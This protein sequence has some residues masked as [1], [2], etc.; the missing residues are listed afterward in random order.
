MELLTALAV[1]VTLAV[2]DRGNAN[3]SLAAEG[4]FVA[5]VWS[6][7]A[8]GGATDIYSATSRDGGQTFSGPVRVNAKPGDARVNGEQPPRVVLVARRGGLPAL[9]VIWTARGET[10]TRLLSSRSDDGGRTFGASTIL[11][12]VDAAGNR[13]WQ[14]AAAG[15]DGV[16]RTLWLDH[17]ELATHESHAS[18]SHPG[19]HSV[20]P[21]QN[22]SRAAKR[23]GVALAQLSKLYIGAAGGS[24]GAPVAIT[25]GVCYCCKTALAAGKGEAMFA[26]WRHVYP[27]NIRDIAFAASRDGGRTFTTPIRVSQ[28]Q[29]ALDGCPDD[30]PAMAVDAAGVV[31]VAWPTV[32][33]RPEPHKSIF[34]SWSADGRTFAPRARI[35]PIGRNVAHPQIVVHA[36]GVTVVWD[37]VA[38]GTRKVFAARRSRSNRNFAPVLLSDNDTPSSYPAAVVSGDAIVTA[39]TAGAPGTSSIAVRR[40]PLN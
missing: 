23:D 31:H 2:P 4:R 36:A 1:V 26:A 16:V 12:G 11:T 33:E 39:W 9:V 15:P 7:S 17:R 13:G 30:G 22:A 14:S 28:D 37:Q 10:G 34:Y 38:D 3:V 21:E 32:V 29:W 40:I 25:G 35:T 18:G 19:G 5:A 6:A 8:P 24:A 20:N 27:G